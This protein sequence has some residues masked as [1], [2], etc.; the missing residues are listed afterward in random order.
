MLERVKI[1][2]DQLRRAAE[3]VPQWPA[4]DYAGGMT[5]PQT[6]SPT[7]RTRGVVQ[8]I[9]G[10]LAVVTGF[11]LTWTFF[12]TT[13]RGQRLDEAAWGGSGVLGDWPRQV[14]GTVLETI[15]PTFLVAVVL[16]AVLIA[17]AQ[18]RW[19][20]AVA[21]AIVLGGS[22]VTTQVFKR[23]VERPD[24]DVSMVLSNSFPSGHTTVAA[25]V[26]AAALLISPHR[27]R[28]LVALL[29]LAYAGA[30]GVATLMNGWHR[31]SDVVGAYL[32]VAAWFFAAE[33]ARAAGSPTGVP[34]GYRAPK[35]VHAGALLLVTGIVSL[36]VGLALLLLMARA[37][38]GAGELNQGLSWLGGA[39]GA[40]G[41]WALCLRGMLAM[42]PL[43]S[44]RPG[45]RLLRSRHREPQTIPPPY[46]PVPRS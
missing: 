41:V 36:A 28:G 27:F 40:L 9:V 15:S 35:V 23:V 25:S 1:W 2:C 11:A 26:A 14:A 4:C 16:A 45:R 43:V 5:H 22:N 18:R 44:D 46:P 31:P 30:T 38:G 42:R 33:L 29:G 39:T 17:A 21:A 13:V 37:D 12:V 10:V 3:L 7:R 20:I 6:N 24:L 8:P 32:V 19:F 34:R